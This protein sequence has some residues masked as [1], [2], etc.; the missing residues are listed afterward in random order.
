MSGWGEGIS[1]EGS[2]FRSGKPDVSL[3]IRAMRTGALA[4]S[5][6]IS[7]CSLSAR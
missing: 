2:Y 5:E 1:R 6:S 3:C 7:R 4:A